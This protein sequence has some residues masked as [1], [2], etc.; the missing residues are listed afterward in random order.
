MQ[1]PSMPSSDRDDGKATYQA[2]GVFPSAT[3]ATV[4]VTPVKSLFPTT[5]GVRKRGSS[6]RV[7]GIAL[8]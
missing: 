5:S 8:D 3:R 6:S 4:S 2:K 7:V 1:T